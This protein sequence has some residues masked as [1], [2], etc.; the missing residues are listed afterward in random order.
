MNPDN[1]SKFKFHCVKC[2]HSQYD[3]AQFYASGSFW[4][5]VFNIEN[6]K[7]TTITCQKCFYTELYK[8][9]SSKFGNV[10]DFLGN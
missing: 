5:K 2:N 3:M 10:I 6:K 4:A 1:Q 9:P 7:F 8:I